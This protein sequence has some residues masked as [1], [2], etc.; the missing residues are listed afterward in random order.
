MILTAFSLGWERLPIASRAG[1]ITL[2][3]QG[4][5]LDRCMFARRVMIFELFALKEESIFFLHFS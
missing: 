1:G 5:D 3:L 2:F 4:K